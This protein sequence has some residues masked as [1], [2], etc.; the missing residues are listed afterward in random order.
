MRCPWFARIQTSISPIRFLAQYA[1]FGKRSNRIM[2]AEDPSQRRE[3]TE[4][5]KEIQ[6]LVQSKGK[7]AERKVQCNR[8]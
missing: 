1:C 8:V 3:E 7:G 4:F 5:R 2:T 6:F